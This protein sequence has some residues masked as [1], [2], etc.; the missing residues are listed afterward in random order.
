MDGA[1]EAQSAEIRRLNELLDRL[2]GTAPLDRARA[3]GLQA[4]STGGGGRPR[5]VDDGQ[6][7]EDSL[8]G[9][10]H[11]TDFVDYSGRQRSS[12]RSRAAASRDRD[13]RREPSRER[14]RSDRFTRPEERERTPRLTEELLRR[15]VGHLERLDSLADPAAAAALAGSPYSRS[16][17]HSPSHRSVSGVG[18]DMQPPGS[19][20]PYFAPGQSFMPGQNPYPYQ[21]P[22]MPPGPSPL[23]QAWGYTPRTMPFEQQPSAQFGPYGAPVIPGFAPVNQF[24][25]Q[26]SASVPVVTIPGVTPNG[27]PAQVIVQ[28]T[29]AA[30]PGAAGNNA[31]D[32]DHRH[33]SRRSR[34][35]SPYAYGGGHSHRRA[36]VSTVDSGASVR[37]DETVTLRCNVVD[38][39][40]LE[41]LVLRLQQRIEELQREHGDLAVRAKQVSRARLRL[42]QQMNTFRQDIATERANHEE[43][44]RK[45]SRVLNEIFV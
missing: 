44:L 37:T 23:P 15:I 30:F 38:H 14:S 43:M 2:S 5:L 31:D 39:H 17:S 20:G 10:V 8:S 24:G 28:S 40:E 34:S 26:A 25:G 11:D 32:R 33:R 21:Y 1:L 35:H 45:V 12:S 29:P 19:F 9:P 13:G 3:G 41:N 6:R 27:L 4:Q 18:F 42:R 36:S 16:R 22:S 7:S